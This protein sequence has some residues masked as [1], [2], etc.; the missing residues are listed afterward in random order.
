MP[1]RDVASAW[2]SVLTYMPEIPFWPQLPKRSSEEG[3]A[4]QF[5]EHLPG[6]QREGDKFY[7]DTSRATFWEEIDGFYAHFAQGD[8][9]LFATS[10]RHAAG[11]YAVRDHRDTLRESLYSKGQITGPISMGL[12]L[13]DENLRPI[14]YHEVLRD[15][16]VKNLLRA[17]QWQESFLRKIVAK[18]IILID[19]PSLALIGAAHVSIDPRQ[20]AQDL[21]EVLSGIQTWRGIHCCGNT[22]WPLLLDTSIEIISLDAFQYM[23]NFTLFPSQ[24]RAFLD[25]GGNIAWGIVPAQEEFLAGETVDSLIRRLEEGL[26][27]LEKA[28]LDREFILRRSLITPSCGVG[29]QTLSGAENIL[30]MTRQVSNRLRE[31]YGL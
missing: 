26:G 18:T 12:S 14:L 8:L 10:P 7:I 2:T 13:H 1:H 5:A 28:G 29:Q 25:H 9:E 30:A 17:A 3:M 4:V 27:P 22:D 11:L 31:K 23:A 20:V 15:V 16:L 21:E 24:I 19:E 6:A